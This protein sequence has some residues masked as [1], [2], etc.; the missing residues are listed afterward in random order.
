MKTIG[1]RVTYEPKDYPVAPWARA[2]AEAFERHRMECEHHELTQ[3]KEDE[4][5]PQKP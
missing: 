4:S 1:T 5:C 3:L 2:M